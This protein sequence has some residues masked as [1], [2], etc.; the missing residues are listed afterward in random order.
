VSLREHHGNPSQ[1]CL[2]FYRSFHSIIFKRQ[3]AEEVDKYLEEAK[4]AIKS[5][6][7]REMLLE[8]IEILANS[9]KILRILKM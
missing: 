7:S 3:E 2:P 9:L 1:F 6:K 5:S 8:A 4:T